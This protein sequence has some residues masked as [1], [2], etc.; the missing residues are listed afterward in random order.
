MRSRL[1][2]SENKDINLTSEYELPQMDI[3]WIPEVIFIIHRA[4]KK[5]ERLQNHDSGCVENAISG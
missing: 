1:K 4:Q 3:R 2:I 5:L